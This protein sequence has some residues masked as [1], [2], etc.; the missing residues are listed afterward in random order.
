MTWDTDWLPV[1]IM[2]WIGR[3]LLVGLLV[4]VSSLPVVTLPAAIGAGAAAHAGIG[5]SVLSR[6]WEAFHSGWHR[7]LPIGLLTIVLT[8]IVGWDLVWA[9]S[10]PLGPVTTPVVAAALIMAW[11]GAAVCL[12]GSRRLAGSRRVRDVVTGAVMEGARSPLKPLA[13]LVAVAV[14]ALVALVC[15]P[16]VVVA[17]GLDC[18]VI[19]RLAPAGHVPIHA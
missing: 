9:T 13:V 15:L 18:V 17:L 4:L 11:L 10:R 8:V 5:G 3:V 16:M 1:R 7:S 12:L 19:A 2:T 14:T 6:Y